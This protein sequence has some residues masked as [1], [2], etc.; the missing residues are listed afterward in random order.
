MQSHEDML[1][2]VARLYYE[3]Q[4]T[5]AEIGRRMNTSRS[6]VS[7]MLKE[8]RDL[9]VVNIKINYPWKRIYALENELCQRFD[10]RECRVL[11][12]K[13]RPID[14][15]MKGMGLLA[16]DFLDNFLQDGMTLGVSYGRTIA[17]V[18]EQLAPSKHID[19]TVVQILGA[20]GSG[21]PL[22]EGPDLVRSLANLYKA[23]YHY[24]Y[25]PLLVESNHTRDLLMQEPNISETLKRGRQADTVILGIGAHENEDS[26]L[27]WTGY[28][29]K[30][31]FAFL[32]SR[33][34]VGHMAAQHYDQ[35]GKVLDI[36]LNKRVIS[37]G[38]EALKQIE[39]VIAIAGSTEKAPAISGALKGKYIDVLITDDTAAAAILQLG[40]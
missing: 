14:Q 4:L 34:A 39:T 13:D 30:K 23:K 21:N 2:Q 27:I 18:I 33:G 15:T 19:L 31:E 26:G 9:G 20:L 29:G 22:I 1:V 24:L 6:T 10:L 17:A 32:K 38:L 35:N 37:I 5:Q 25:T 36:G 11:E 16:A 7:R 40:E 28:M 3:D 8:C 12:S